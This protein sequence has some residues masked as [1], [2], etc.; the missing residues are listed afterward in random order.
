MKARK[1]IK[2]KSSNAYTLEDVKQFLKQQIEIAEKRERNH[3][4]NS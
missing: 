2:R 1:P 4:H 3:E